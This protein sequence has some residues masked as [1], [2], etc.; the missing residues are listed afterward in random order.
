VS[1][2]AIRASTSAVFASSE[3]WRCA[4]V[5]A[6]CSRSSGGNSITPSTNSAQLVQVVPT[7]VGYLAASVP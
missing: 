4:S 2:P 3:S 7:D 5:G 6:A 1:L